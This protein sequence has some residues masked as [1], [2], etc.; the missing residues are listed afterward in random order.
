MEEADG[1]SDMERGGGVGSG[2]GGGGGVG[3][4][5]VVRWACRY[6]ISACKFITCNLWLLIVVLTINILKLYKIP[7]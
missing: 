7:T 4:S 3:S 1:R 6:E 2:G 5:R